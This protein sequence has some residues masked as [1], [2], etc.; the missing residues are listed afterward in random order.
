ML[1]VDGRAGS[2]SGRCDV[3]VCV[4][5]LRVIAMLQRNGNGRQQRTSQVSRDATDE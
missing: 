5:A 1:P 3:S 2:R 4:V